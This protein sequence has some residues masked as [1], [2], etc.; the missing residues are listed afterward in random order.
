MS[1]IPAEV[2]RVLQGIEL[3]GVDLI[4]SATGA[5]S[6]RAPSE[7]QTGQD[8]DTHDDRDNDTDEHVDSLGG[9]IGLKKQ[10]KQAKIRLSKNFITLHLFH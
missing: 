5:G 2:E 6:P 1:T 3:E 8:S 7:I 10:P 4:A 9:D